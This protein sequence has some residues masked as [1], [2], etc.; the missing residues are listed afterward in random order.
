MQM[1]NDMMASESTAATDRPDQTS[2]WECGSNLQFLHDMTNLTSLREKHGLV[3][4]SS[5]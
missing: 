1:K 3:L 2:Q 4:K 5:F